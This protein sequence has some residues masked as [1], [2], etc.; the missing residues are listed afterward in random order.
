MD[1][2]MNESRVGQ[3][4]DE[5][6]KSWSMS[7]W[8]KQELANE[9]VTQVARPR[10][11]INNARSRDHWNAAQLLLQVWAFQVSVIMCI[12]HSDFHSVSCLPGSPA[13]CC[14]LFN[15]KIHPLF[16]VQKSHLRS[17]S[18]TVFCSSHTAGNSRALPWIFPLPGMHIPTSHGA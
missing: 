13:P 14:V 16:Q 6:I 17:V 4:V 15:Q 10:V 7:G 3:W 18:Q 8:M 12:N 2:W 1:E 11:F 5:W 9:S